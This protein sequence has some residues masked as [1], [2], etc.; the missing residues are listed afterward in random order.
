MATITVSGTRSQTPGGPSAVSAPTGSINLN[1]TITNISG[2]LNVGN[3][4]NIGGSVSVGGNLYV[5]GSSSLTNQVTIVSTITSVS[6][7]TG[8][9]VVG[10]GVGIGENLNVGG[11]AVITGTVVVYNNASITG[12]I[13]VVGSTTTVIIKANDNNVG[14]PLGVEYTTTNVYGTIDQRL[15]G[16]VYVGGGVGIEKDLNVG[17]YIYGRVAKSDQAAQTLVTSTNVDEVFYPIFVNKLGISTATFSYTYIDNINTGTG[18]TTST[19]GLT[20][21]PYSG[22]LTTFNEAITGPQNSVGTDTGALT[23]AGGVGIANSSFM[24]GNSVVIDGGLTIQVPVV[25]PGK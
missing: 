21:N 9:L 19:G 5:T 7:T 22:L 24:T 2:Q 14:N 15:A 6:T 3:S 25:L 1:S 18:G 12:T 17:G 23:V 8:A 11:N 4:S 16:A 13:T 10:G 20:Y